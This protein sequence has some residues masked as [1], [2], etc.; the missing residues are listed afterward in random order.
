M[1]LINYW[2]NQ[3]YEHN[4][5]NKYYC[6]NETTALSKL[7]DELRDNGLKMEDELFIDWKLTRNLEVRQAG[8]ETY[9]F[10]EEVDLI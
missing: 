3:Y 6:E 9:I 5:W 4:I 7:N 2:T 10:I 8:E 1:I